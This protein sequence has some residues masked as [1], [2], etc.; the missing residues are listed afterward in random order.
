MY[1][2]SIRIC[3]RYTIKHQINIIIREFNINLD[4]VTT[5]IKRIKKEYI[6]ILLI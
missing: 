5:E 1:A 4:Y 2:V 3:E 6:L